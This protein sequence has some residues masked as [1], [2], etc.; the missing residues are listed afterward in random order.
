[1][2]PFIHSQIFYLAW[3]EC[4][5]CNKDE[6]KAILDAVKNRL[7]HKDFPDSLGLILN[8]PFQFN[9]DKVY[10]PKYFKDKVEILWN[11]PIKYPYIY[12]RSKGY[13]YS[14][15]MN[16]YTWIKHKKFKHEFAI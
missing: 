7:E 4:S 16:K 9:V 15:W 2:K 12:F 14:S 3:N 8:A 6:I 1:M 5:I 10:V 11:Q 13:K